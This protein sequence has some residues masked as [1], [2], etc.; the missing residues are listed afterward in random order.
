M[1]RA[2]Y[3]FFVFRL[4]SFVV[5]F[6]FSFVFRERKIVLSHNPGKYPWKSLTSAEQ[7]PFVGVESRRC[8][9]FVTFSAFEANV[10][11]DV[12]GSNGALHRIENFVANV[13]VPLGFFGLFPEM[14][15]TS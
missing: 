11:I 3:T 9:F 1:S 6:H 13:A 15:V 12:F 2:Y 4:S 14:G 7:L 5:F 8:K 10:V